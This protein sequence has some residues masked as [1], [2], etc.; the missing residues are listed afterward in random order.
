MKRLHSIPACCLLLFPAPAHGQ[1]KPE[2]P[3]LAIVLSR[4]GIRAPVHAL[5]DYS[6]SA[7][8]DLESAWHVREAGYLTPHGAQAM[9]LLGAYY[10]AHYVALG[11]L[12]GNDCPAGQIYF[13]A[14]VTERTEASAAGLV[15][16]LGCNTP[17]ET[18]QSAQPSCVPGKNSTDPLFHPVGSVGPAPDGKRAVREILTRIGSLDQLMKKYAAP[19]RAL[20]SALL[21]CAKPTV[22]PDGSKSCTLLD[23]TSSLTPGDGKG[24]DWEG[25]FPIGSNAAETF[26]LEYANQ[27]DTG[28]GRVTPESLLGMMLV[29]TVYFEY[30]QRTPYLAAVG[31]SNLANY[32]VNTMAQAATGLS[33]GTFAPAGSRLVVLVGHDTNIANIAGMLG[34]SWTLAGYQK[35]DPAPGGALVFELYERANPRRHVVRAYYQSQSL[36]Q[37]RDAVK[38]TNQEPP[39]RAEIA[40]PGCRNPESPFDCP[41]E[42]FQAIVCGAIDLQFV[43]AGGSICPP[44]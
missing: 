39:S 4:H 31:G 10:R 44:R 40:I 41:Y 8:P 32:V 36:R 29:H 43:S 1:T 7:W 15:T 34:L 35:D 17:I 13:R 2:T 42:K 11:L 14:D 27:M 9:A 19:M 3:K 37:M 12:N 20:Q 30:S 18:C 5:T 21:C 26:Q 28:W 6:R 25:S 33:K 24:I 38:L 23:L 22:C 16:G